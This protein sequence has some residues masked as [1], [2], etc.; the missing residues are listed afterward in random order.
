MTLNLTS[1]NL[2]ELGWT[3]SRVETLRR[4]YAEGLSSSRIAAELGGG[5]TRNAV[6]GKVDRL[7]LPKRG[8]NPTK[9]SSAHAPA[10]KK[11][12]GKRGREAVKIVAPKVRVEAPVVPATVHR[13]PKQTGSALRTIIDNI[14][15]IPFIET[16]N[17]TCKWPLWGDDT[18][19]D[20]RRCCGA[21]VIEGSSY[22]QMHADRAAG[23]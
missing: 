8:N 12:Q 5:V 20:E 3:E 15:G 21:G 17:A 6:I 10:A 16:T 19:A 22:C 13:L 1:S 18:P 4:L 11:L 9:A 7:N 23:R 2:A 14:E